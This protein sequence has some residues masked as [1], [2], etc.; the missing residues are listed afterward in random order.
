M[1]PEERLIVEL[2]GEVGREKPPSLAGADWGKI[3]RL[4]RANRLT[5]PIFD[6]LDR[7]GLLSELPEDVRKGFEADYLRQVTEIRSALTLAADLAARFAAA[8]VGLVVLR[9]LALG[10]TVYPRPFLRSFSDLD[11]LVR[12][13]DLP[14]AKAVLREAGLRPAPGTFPERYFERHHLHL[15]YHHPP[16][17]FPVE[18][19]WALDHPYT[20]SRIDYPALI[21]GRREATFE[22]WTIPVLAPEDRVLTLALHL[23]KHCPFLPEFLEEEDFSSLLLRGRWLLWVLDLRRAASPAGEQLDWEAIA[24]KA[25]RWNL[26]REVSVCLA[27]VAAVYGSLPEEVSFPA[28]RSARRGWLRKELFRRQL[29]Y[30]KDRP[31]SGRLTQRLFGLRAE[32][33][34]R[35]VRLLD[36]SGY[37]FPGRGWLEKR[38]R[39]R[40][41]A[42]IPAAFLHAARGLGLLIGNLLDYLYF[43]FRSE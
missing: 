37:L 20:L 12:K 9:G 10:L 3:R 32:T 1:G 22:G 39:V 14:R 33:V 35:P 36:L 25:R 23:V 5:G 4:A 15:P 8:G 26:E 34:F 41:F 17:G 42:V 21:A 24:E 19:H 43:R 18:L 27:A 2:T 7:A 13:S 40:G 11:L 6:G 30:L 31:R 28:P 29:L 16:T 38:Y